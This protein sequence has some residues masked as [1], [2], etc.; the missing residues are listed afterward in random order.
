MAAAPPRQPPLRPVAR[1]AS[2]HD[3]PD[4]AVVAGLAQR[5]RAV[6]GEDLRTDVG[7]RALYAS[8]ASSY[9][10]LPRLVAAPRSVEQLAEVVGRCAEAGLPVTPR[11]A[12]T[13]I[14]GNAIGPGLV[15]LT[16]HLAGIG[17]V[18]VEARA[19]T[20]GPGAVL[21]DV[22][23]AAA[24]HGL[25]FGPEPSTHDRC[26]IGGMV[27]ND[28]C[29]A[30]SV[31]WGSTA[32]N[33]E[34]L[35][36]VTATG[37]RLA[38]GPAP[39]LGPGPGAAALAGRLRSIIDPSAGLIRAELPRWHRRVSGYALDRLLPERGFDVARALVGTEGTCAIVTAAA[40]RLVPAPP[41]RVLL[42]LG[43]PDDVA[44]ATDVPAL[45]T[46]EPYTVEAMSV[47]LIAAYRQ[48]V[49]GLLP[50]GASW[51]L[52]EAGG[53]GAPEARA[54]AERLARSVS[55]DLRHASVRL[56]EDAAAQ[57]AV[58]RMRE[59]ASGR[60]SRLPDGSP[61]WPG[62]EDAVVPPERLAA[63]LAA[64]RALLA[65]HGLVGVTY[66][67]FGEGCIHVRLGFELGRPD[68]VARFRAFMEEAADLVVAH[69]GSLSG[70]HGDG[71][72]RSELL[73]RQFSPPLLSLFGAFKSAWDPRGLLNPGVIVDP[74]PIDADLRPAEPTRLPLRPDL[75]YHADGGDLRAAVQRCIGV[76]RCVV[77]EGPGLMCP[78]YRA[79]RDERH[80]TRGRARLLQEMMAGSLAEPGWASEDVRDALDLCLGCKGCL[81]ECPVSVDMA[82]Y[83]SE[84]LAQHY[85]GRLRPRTHYSLGW[86]PLWLRL[87]SRLPRLANAALRHPLGQALYRSLGGVAA[88]VPLPEL[89]P[90]TLVALAGG[91]TPATPGEGGVRRGRVVL[92]PDSFTNHLA[93]GIGQAAIRVLARAGYDVV[94][95]RS[96][97]CCGLTWMTTGQLGR[98]RSTLRRSLDAPELGGDEPVLVLE[99]SCAAALVTDAPHL[100]GDDAG[101]RRIG[102]RVR[103]LAGLLDGVEL[104]G[105]DA[106]AALPGPDAAV[107][108]A[109][110]LVQPHCHQQAVLGTDV[111]ARLMARAGIR[112]DPMLDGCCGMA[113]DWGAAS[114]RVAM[115][116]AVADLALAPALRDLGEDGLVLADGFSCRMQVQR[117]SGRRARH[118]AEVLDERVSDA[119]GE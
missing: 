62:F 45:V 84:F 118:L 57:R 67:H 8:D 101:A 14:A 6:L 49:Q 43:Y 26:T 79:T 30:R 17:D 68:G 103:T 42:L 46:A 92:W 22:Q 88:D 90:R 77:R 51:L 112:P 93:P 19:V 89:A 82:T 34:A 44:A 104:P 1:R 110:A 47:E 11:G 21:D 50:E 20:V 73:A 78:S 115:S 9:R 35:E 52:V 94:V 65:E 87:G 64:F 102:G 63:Y 41:A 74:A 23:R 99:P 114:G 80:S 12:G 107:A 58:W 53:D 39:A 15:L 16:R 4:G 56:V 105:L 70:E 37:L 96:P 31:R 29:G 72:A 7:T 95:P 55:R 54:H 28:A 3:G 117:L 60:A 61:A 111:D 69:G 76:G 109:G 116:Q 85:R 13:S 36:V 81:R 91:E 32:D 48:R 33:I 10:V 75:A 18:D 113:G 24:A 106:G 38:A 5:L 40:L 59:D 119:A 100:L 25:R 66:G 71:R 83:R 27:G 97:V 108:P 2:L 86:L 98:A